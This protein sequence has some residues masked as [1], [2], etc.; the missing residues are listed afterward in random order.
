MFKALSFFLVAL[1]LSGKVCLASHRMES[2]EPTTVPPTT[3]RAPT[4]PAPT[5]T[6]EPAFLKNVNL[7]EAVSYDLFVEDHSAGISLNLVCN[8]REARPAHVAHAAH[9]AP[10]K[11]YL[12]KQDK[13]SAVSPLQIVKNFLHK[14]PPHVSPNNLKASGKQHASVGKNLKEGQLD[15]IEV[16]NENIGIHGRTQ[17]SIKLNANL[18]LKKHN[19]MG[20][21]G[22]SRSG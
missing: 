16:L 10:H 2:G 19:S 9:A 15:N 18:P 22:A 20:K 21:Q 17:I 11:E 1:C 6:T 5:T 4:T 14:P 8:A 12:L 13:K 7:S 3:T